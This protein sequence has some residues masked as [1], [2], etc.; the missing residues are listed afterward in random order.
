MG[1]IPMRKKQTAYRLEPGLLKR[2][3]EQAE[4]EHRNATNMVE[5][6]LAEGLSKREGEIRRSKSA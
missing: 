4:R 6:L 3:M 5:V 2:L 1:V